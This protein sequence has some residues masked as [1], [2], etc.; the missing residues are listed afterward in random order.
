MVVHLRLPALG[1]INYM[2]KS[3]STIISLLTRRMA[4][5]LFLLAL[6]LAKE[7]NFQ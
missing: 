1:I 6:L 7:A 4:K 2:G 3:K 5:P